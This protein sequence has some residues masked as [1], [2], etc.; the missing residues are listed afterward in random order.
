MEKIK[1][2]LKTIVFETNGFIICKFL[3]HNSINR[4]IFVKGYLF[5]L[6]PEQLYELQGQFVSHP[7]YGKQF[8]VEQYETVIIEDNEYLVKYLSSPLFPTIG[9]TTAQKIIDCLQDD[10]LNKI[11]CDAK[12]LFNIGIKKNQAQIIYEQIKKQK[13]D[14]QLT[15]WFSR[16]QLSFD[17]LHKLQAQY[18]EK[19]LELI[20]VN[21]YVLSDQCEFWTFHKADQLARVL[22]INLNNV[23]RLVYALR[24]IIRQE[25]FKTGHSYFSVNI[26]LKQLMKYSILDEKLINQ[27]VMQAINENKIIVDNNNFYDIEIYYSEIFIAKYLNQLQKLDNNIND[28]VIIQDIHIIEQE[29]NISYNNEQQLALLKFSQKNLTIINGGPGTG[30]TTLI[31]GIIAL[32]QKHY[33]HNTVA[34]CAPTGRAAKRLKE[35]TNVEAITIHKLLKWDLHHNKFNHNETEPLNF[36]LIVVDEMSMVDTILFNN[37]LVASPNL[38]KLVLVGDNNQLTSVGS[39]NVLGDLL[40]VLHLNII[41]L[42]KVYRQLE[43]SEIINLAYQ[44]QQN[45]FSYEFTNSNEVQFIEY[46]QIQQLLENLAKIF[47]QLVNESNIFEVQ[48]LASMYNGRCGI[49]AINE[50]LQEAYNPFCK[51]KMQIKIATTIF[52]V[53]D[54]VMQTKNDSEKDIYNGDIGIID[55]IIT[56]EQNKQVIIIRYEQRIIE[57]QHQE[58]NN[59]ILAYA[60]SVHKSQ[61]SEYPFV[62]MII[63]NSATYM[64]KRNLIYT[65]ITRCQKKLY[66]LGQKN[67]FIKAVNSLEKPRIT[68]L[69][70]RLMENKIIHSGKISS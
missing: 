54:K 70:K 19:L 28:A 8:Q 58:L 31:K 46:Y 10:V 16:A 59:L 41:S 22:E 17:L 68:T 2:Y 14:H 24:Y 49:N 52:R 15:Q 66:L 53:G 56:N 62:I 67:I 51:D 55:N 12:I 50:I 9:K 42:Q 18:G 32:Y 25:S 7:K 35:Q 11:Y 64:L 26:I 57:Y 69:V 40:Q 5:N 20:K 13:N 48:V 45:N 33:P 36:D 65:A 39:G 43:K 61:G 1:G 60:I 37:L 6:Q 47:L 44:M 3:L 38:H 63:D 34:I 4:Y 27:V 21:P 30:K 23:S 29:N